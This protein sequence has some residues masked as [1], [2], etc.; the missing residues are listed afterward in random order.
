MNIRERLKLY[1]DLEAQLEV[2]ASSTRHVVKIVLPCH[3]A[4]KVPMSAALRIFLLDDEALAR[5]RLRELLSDILQLPTDVV[6]EADR[7][8][9][10]A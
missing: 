4:K 9:P 7:C 2:I 3:W 8:T 10:S 6:G 1:Y 5:S